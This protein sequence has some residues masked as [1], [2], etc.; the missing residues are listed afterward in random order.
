M[1]GGKERRVRDVV[2]SMQGRGTAKSLQEP[3]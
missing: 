1:Y 3:G 2:G